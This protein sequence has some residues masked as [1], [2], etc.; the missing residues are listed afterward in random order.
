MNVVPVKKFSPFIVPLAEGCPDFVMAQAVTAT[1]AD[2]C[3]ATGCITTRT[4]FTTQ[5]GESEYDLRLN[6]GL[7]PE[8]V[9]SVYCDGRQ[10]EACRL[11]EL[12]RRFGGADWREAVGVP[13]YYTFIRPGTLVLTPAPDKEMFVSVTLTCSVSRMTETVPEEFF[14]DYLDTVVNGALARIYRIQGQ[15]YTN[16]RL[17]EGYQ[18]KY[19]AGLNDIRLDVS[20]DFTRGTGRVFYNRIV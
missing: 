17:A 5:D 1:V 6:F 15:T 3:K 4:C 7:N 10:V 18:A 20:R 14:V 16:V 12:D 8:L 19:E 9:R 2:I 11:D 13:A